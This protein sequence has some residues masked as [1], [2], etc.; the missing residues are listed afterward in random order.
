M[1]PADD[2][3]AE[4]NADDGARILQAGQWRT[5]TPI[6]ESLVSGNRVQAVP[7]PPEDPIP[8]QVPT[9]SKVRTIV[10][11]CVAALLAIAILILLIAR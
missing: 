8:D 5:G 4:Q 1:S 6:P 10:T 7:S 9:E 2:P 3:L 11:I